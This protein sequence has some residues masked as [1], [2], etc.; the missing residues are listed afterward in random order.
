MKSVFRSRGRTLAAP[1][2]KFSNAQLFVSGLVLSCAAARA[3][4]WTGYRGVG[5]GIS[6]EHLEVNWPSAGPKRLWRIETPNGFSSFAVADGQA[7]TVI[8]RNKDGMPSETCVGVDAESGRELWSAVTGVARYDQGGDN[9]ADDNKGGDGPRSTPAARDGRVFVYSSAMV[10]HCL[11]A[12]TGKMNWKKDIIAEFGGENIKW[13]SAMSPVLHA[14]RVFVAGGGKGSTMIAFD[15]RT[16]AVVWKRGGDR[17]T[18]ATPV[19]TTIHG[20]AQVIF[21][22]QSGLVSANEQD[23]KELWRYAF[24]FRVS[25]EITPVVGGDVVFCSAGYDVGSG[26]CQILKTNG[27]FEAKELWR[28]HG[29]KDVVTQWSTP[30]E[31]NGHL[32]GMFSAKKFGAGPLKCVEMKTGMVKWE[33]EG[34][35]VG[36]VIL[37]GDQLIALTDNG[38]VVVVEPN[39]AAYK[40]VARFKAVQGKCWSTPALSNGHLYVRSVKEGACFDL[41]GKATADAGKR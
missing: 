30:V 13:K 33:Q 36:N 21:F 34:F 24:P 26:A 20:V 38:Q 8:T 41:R 23:G 28:A 29:N 12:A 16:G 14:D 25:T 27:G 5:D 15:Q 22:L 9:G 2:R 6:A 7:F 4:D 37:A 31:R 3:S 39:S 11:D 18:H 19:V 40:E 10:L 1:A 35:G 32:Y 17:M